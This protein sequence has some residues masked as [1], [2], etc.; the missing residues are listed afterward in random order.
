M[1][2]LI[3]LIPA[4]IGA[5]GSIIGGKMAG[6]Q[7]SQQKA[8]L[9]AQTQLAQQQTANAKAG[10]GLSTQYS[11]M[12][13]PALTNALSYWQSLL[14]GDR[15]AMSSVLGPEIEQYKQGTA[16]ATDNLNQF[17]PRGGAR[18]STLAELPYSTARTI[19]DMFATVRPVA[20]AQTGALGT[21]LAGLGINALNSSTGAAGSASNDYLSQLN[22]L[23]QQKQN[24]FNTAAGIGKGLY[25]WAKGIDWGKLG[26]GNGSSGNIMLEE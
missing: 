18:T 8:A 9:D 21:G 25:S 3:P 6:S 19:G 1:P 11:G 7:S 5:A 20:A 16:T 26:A 22:Y 2:A 13:A 4:A 23:N 14:G 10:A 24:Q 12:A 17:A 15:T